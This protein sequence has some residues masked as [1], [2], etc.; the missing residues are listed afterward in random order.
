MRFSQQLLPVLFI[1]RV[2]ESI[3]LRDKT[4]VDSEIKQKK[5]LCSET[6]TKLSLQM[7][8]QF[9][10]WKVSNCVHHT[11]ILLVLHRCICIYLQ[12]VS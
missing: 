5:I 1:S 10:F 2:T 4:P 3:D 9:F 8:L 7:R 6:K 11:N 12:L